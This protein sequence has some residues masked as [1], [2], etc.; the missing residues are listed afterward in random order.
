MDSGMKFFSRLKAK[1]PGPIEPL[2]NGN[3]VV[4]VSA[5]PTGANKFVVV[6]SN[7]MKQ[8][9]PQ[10]AFYSMFE[11]PEPKAPE[12]SEAPAKAPA[13]SKAK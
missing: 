4:E 6:Y 2:K 13:K 1:L 8:T 5:T 10:D 12:P 9:W 3:G 7:G 11:L